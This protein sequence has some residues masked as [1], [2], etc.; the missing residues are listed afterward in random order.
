MKKSL[1]WALVIFALYYLVHDPAAAAHGAGALG[2]GLQHA[3]NSLSK[4]VSSL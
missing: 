2:Q 1:T 3:A 4:V